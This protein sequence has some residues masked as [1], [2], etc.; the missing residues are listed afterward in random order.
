MFFISSFA[1][2]SIEISNPTKRAWVEAPVVVA[3]NEQLNTLGSTDLVLYGSE[4][5]PVQVDDL[6]GDRKPDEIV[7]L[8]NL[9]PG[10]TKT[11][12]VKK[13]TFGFEPPPRAHAGMYL[14]GIEGAGWESDRLAFRIY[15]DERNA[16]DIYC[17]RTP[18]L[19]LEQY[20]RP[21]VNYH[22]E[23]PWGMDVLKVGPA[24]G[25]GGFGVW[26]DD[27]VQKV[28]KTDRDFKVIVNG[29]IRAVVD[30]IYTNWSV[31]S[32]KFNLNVRISMIAG[33]R[34]SETEL[35]LV[36]L[37]DG[38]YPEFVTGVVIHD[39]TTLIQDKA[40]GILGRWGLQAL[41]PGEKPKG[42][43]L[44][45]GVVV[46]PAD[47]V[48]FGDDG[49]NSF[50]RLKGKMESTSEQSEARQPMYVQYKSH[51]SWVN[52]PGGADS[53]QAYETMLRDL[54]LLEPKVSFSNK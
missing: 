21:E 8:V 32:R 14:K 23:T 31:G 12:T 50:V 52:E 6:D 33:Q 43:N 18:V 3:W 26:L 48:E 30:L 7:F 45:F 25:V 1:E 53:T 28:V 47:I 41:A 11:Y 38:A 27:K 22:V 54:A 24:L 46:C 51:A 13:N 35:R 42:S 10:E 4:L 19:G 49:I 9:R 36:P 34:W 37:D 15:W 2:L 40:A 39:E 44:G 29:P 20:A 16:T 5:L 17:K